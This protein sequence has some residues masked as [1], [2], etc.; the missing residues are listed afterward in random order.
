MLLPSIII[1]QYKFVSFYAIFTY[2]IMYYFLNTVGYMDEELL[3]FWCIDTY[4]GFIF[5]IST[6]HNL[7]HTKIRYNYGL[8]TTIFDRLHNTVHPD[9]VNT[10]RK[11]IVK[12]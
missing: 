4:M 10:F 6:F 12:L 7:H 3:P 2:M 11:N 9:Y 1:S 5:T 8:F